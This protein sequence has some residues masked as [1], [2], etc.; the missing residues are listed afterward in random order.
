[1]GY[2]VGL[3]AVML[4][5]GVVAVAAADD[6]KISYPPTT[7][8]DHFDDYHGVKVADPY[9]WLEEDVRKSKKK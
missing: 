5:G 8:I 3:A 9:R 6:G 7:R 1:M 2:R 4:L